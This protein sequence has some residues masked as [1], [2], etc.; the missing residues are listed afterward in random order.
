MTEPP[1]PSAASVPDVPARDAGVDPAS[2]VALALS[3]VWL[4]GAAAFWLFVPG[5]HAAGGLVS[6]VAVVLPVAVIWMAALMARAARAMR[7]ESARLRAAV[8]ALRATAIGQAPAAGSG[9]RAPVEAKLEEIARAQRQAEAA[10][11]RLAQ[12]GGSLGRSP[13]AA[14]V[15]PGTGPAGAVGR[16]QRPAPAARAR[17]AEAVQP[18][19]ALDPAPLRPVEPIQNEEFIRALNFPEDERD[20][21]G[22]HA[23]RLALK[24]HFSAGLVRS[25]Q[26]VLTLLAEDGIYMDDL[27]PDLARPEVWRRFAQGER[28]KGVAALG[29]IRDRTS[30]SLAS[31]RMRQDPVFRDVAHHFLRKFDHT[32]ADFEP[33]ASDAEIV[34]LADTRT[35]RAFMLLGRVAG[36]F[37]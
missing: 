10:L 33:R 20:A 31:G 12:Q 24:D 27:A 36:T 11:A 28:G 15:G 14:P 8:D 25:S 4:L 35:S 21:Q 30:L 7:E 3:A 17:A 26:D 16:A 32:I 22:F 2:A 13:S 6:L 19:L 34:A 37:D 5:A 18:Q 29:G 1:K 23:L 9:V